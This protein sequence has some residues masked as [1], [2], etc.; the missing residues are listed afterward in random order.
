MKAKSTYMTV[1]TS[2]VTMW[3]LTFRFALTQTEH[4]RPSGMCAKLW[5]SISALQGSGGDGSGLAS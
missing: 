2:K 4:H 5:A 3:G 1:N